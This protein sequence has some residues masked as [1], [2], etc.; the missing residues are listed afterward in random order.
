MKGVVVLAPEYKYRV[1]HAYQ[2][3]DQ[4]KKLSSVH[5]CRVLG[6]NFLGFLR[7]AKNLNASLYP[8]LPQ[9]GNIAFIS[10]SGIFSTAF[11]E[12]AISKKV[13]FSY[14]ISLGSKL[15]INFSDA[16]DFLGRD[17]GTRALFLHVQNINNGRRFMTAIRS[18]E[19]LRAEK[20]YAVGLPPLNQTLAGR[21]MEETKIYQY[22]Q[23]IP[24][25]LGALRS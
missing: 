2:I 16:I 20:D 1:N 25:Y 18:F 10:E 15:D 4:M 8:E 19:Y 3:S 11:L 5:G 24:S 17:G 22:I 13:G 23:G 14:F 12:R 6:P 7:P 21:M 9:I